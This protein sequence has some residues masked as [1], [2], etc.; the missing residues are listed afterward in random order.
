M[1]R[2]EQTIEKIA[3][4]NDLTIARMKKNSQSFFGFDK[5]FGYMED[6]MLQYAGI[7]NQ[8]DPEAPKKCMVVACAD[9]GVAEEGVSAYPVETTIQMTKNY[10]IAKGAGANAMANYCKADLLVVDVG[11]AAP[12]EPIEGLLHR[13]IDFGTQNFT[14]GPAMTQKQAVQALET[15][16]EIATQKIQEG[17]RC[18]CLGEMGIANTTSSAAIVAAFTGLSAEEVTGR[19]T[20]ISD[21]RLKIKIDV[22]RKGLELNQPDS[23]DG[24]DVLAKVGGFELGCLAGVILGAAAGRA[25]VVID[26][27]NASA[28][29]LISASLCPT[30]RQYLIGS[31]LSLEP[32][33]SAALKLLGLK[34]YINM[35]FR[36]GE[37]TGAALAMSILEACLRARNQTMTT[38]ITHF[39]E[40][41]NLN[42]KTLPDRYIAESLSQQAMKDCQH[43]IDNLT[44]P[45]G[46]LGALER[47]TVQLA[48]I[49]DDAKP[50]CVSRSILLFY[51][52]ESKMTCA[53]AGH[54][55]ADIINANAENAVSSSQALA[56][57]MQAADMAV[58]RGSR[59]IGLGESNSFREITDGVTNLSSF[60]AIN[61]MELAALTGAIIAAASH[62]CAIVLDGPLSAMAASIAANISPSIKNYLINANLFPDPLYAKLLSEL[63][64]KAYFEM[65]FACVEGCS[66][67]LG[68]SLLDAGL[69]MLN[70]MKTFKQAA[71]AIAN[72]GPGAK[73]QNLDI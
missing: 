67:A 57:G 36:F 14:K 11:I 66:A 68:I 60:A 5:K 18:F 10:L 29:A 16:I 44:K 1:E 55:G 58:T 22:V 9:H 52:Q 65:D 25:A 8:S 30:A 70:D 47:L 46:S 3:P 31:H 21:E 39:L 72:D 63:G 69:H 45:L 41:T 12:M 50:D 27:F 59:I 56:Y 62:R 17:Y 24:L 48:G 6:I 7:T 32:A 37:A 26:G 4:L 2:L 71:V 13:K 43:Y 20:N 33:H 15:G 51:G 49:L 40:D 61:N 53:F 54:A 19:G 34:A 64:L 23:E 38:A 42:P 28:A 73:R 35:D